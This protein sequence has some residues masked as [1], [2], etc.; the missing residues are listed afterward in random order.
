MQYFHTSDGTK[1]AYYDEGTGVPILCLA[2]LTRNSLDFEYVAPHLSQHRLIRLDYRGRGASQWVKDYTSYNIATEARDALELLD[3]LR[4]DQVAILGTSRG[5]LIA[6]TLAALAKKRLLG[7]CLNDIG[8]EISAE[9]LARIMGY[10]GRSPHFLTAADMAS[11]LPSLMTGFA[12]VAPERWLEEVQHHTVETPQGLDINYDPRLADAVIE[13]GHQPTPDLWPLFDAMT[14]LPLAL[15][16]GANSDLLAPET[17]E[18][19]QK[20]RP[21]MIF[22]EIA[23]RG[24]VPFLDEPAALDAIEKWVGTCR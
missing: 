17:G 18:Q 13:A 21:D 23:D 8:P 6:M 9:G 2:G 5:G 20:R 14:D 10:I 15:I 3:H 22:T 12:N 4:I 24:H 7:I 16:R 11:A 19:M 1:L